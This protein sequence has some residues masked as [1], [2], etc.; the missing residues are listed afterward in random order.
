MKIIDR[1]QKRKT[2]FLSAPLDELTRWTR[3]LRYQWE[4]WGFCAERLRRNN[5]MAMS[6]ALSF[7]TIFAL[8]PALVLA[9]IILK[10]FGLVETTKTG[11]QDIL[12]AV[13][14]D[15]IAVKQESVMPMESGP[16]ANI[17]PATRTVGLS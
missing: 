4:L 13:G 11:I 10:P 9:V 12:S 3:F 17:E 6:S 15:E 5:A 8:I 1:L 7:R 14:V 16:W 2:S